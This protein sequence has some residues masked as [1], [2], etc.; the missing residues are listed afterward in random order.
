MQWSPTLSLSGNPG[1]A[2]RKL[3][4]ALILELS[5]FRIAVMASV[6]CAAGFIISAMPFTMA[7]VWATLGILILSM[8]SLALNQWQERDIDARMPRTR[9]RPIPTG[10]ISSEGALAVAFCLIVAGVLL[11]W[12]GAGPVSALLGWFALLWYNGVYTPLKR[13]SAFAVVPGALI[14]SIPPMAGW[15]ASG[16]SLND[17]ALYAVALFFFI[18]QVPHFWLLLFKYGKQY[19]EARL[20]SLTQVFSDEQ[21]GRLTFMWI[22][23]TATVAVFLPLFGLSRSIPAFAGILAVSVW[24]VFSSAGMLKPGLPES[25]YRAAFRNINVFAMTVMLLLSL[26]TLFG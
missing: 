21:M 11:L 14:G 7:I 5:K 23:A 2:V 1:V 13:V 17:P 16:A 25:S 4:P 12:F 9:N 6:T 8:G 15:A 20:S 24:L 3:S 26:D 22:V 19:E 10:R 18:W